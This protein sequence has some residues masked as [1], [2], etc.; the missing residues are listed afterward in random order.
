MSRKSAADRLLPRFEGFRADPGG[1][2]VDILRLN[3]RYGACILADAW[4]CG[5]LQITTSTSMHRPHA[6]PS[7]CDT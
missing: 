4:V 3:E 6:W 7:R 5:G 1:N 2:W